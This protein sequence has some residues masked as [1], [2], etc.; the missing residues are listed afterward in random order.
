MDL[1]QFVFVKFFEK[2]SNLVSNTCCFTDKDLVKVSSY[3]WDKFEPEIRDLYKCEAYSRNKTRGLAGKK[4]KR[5]F[6]LFTL[7]LEK[8]LLTRD[9]EFS[10]GIWL[11]LDLDWK[12]Y[13]REKTLNLIC[14]EIER[15][16]M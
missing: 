1:S 16:I 12:D 9:I 13:W 3:F 6:W 14:N 11:H 15:V 10:N 2:L 7:D 4:R 5:G 8:A